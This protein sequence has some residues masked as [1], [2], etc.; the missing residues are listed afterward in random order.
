MLANGNY[1]IMQ[2]TMRTINT[3]L[4][5]R[6]PIADTCI[7]KAKIE[8]HSVRLNYYTQQRKLKQWILKSKSRMFTGTN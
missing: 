8:A 4:G 1:L 7:L 5:T 2:K 3:P 6:S